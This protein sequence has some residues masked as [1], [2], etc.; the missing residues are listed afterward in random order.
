MI[1]L[2]TDGVWFR[3]PG[4]MTMTEVGQHLREGQSIA[5]RKRVNGL[6]ESTPRRVLLSPRSEWRLEDDLVRND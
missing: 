1:Y 6:Y 2:Y 3:V 5:V 4:D